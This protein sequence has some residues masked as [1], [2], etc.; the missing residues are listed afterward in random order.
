MS[1]HDSRLYF[2]LIGSVI[3]QALIDYWNP[4]RY[5]N[6]DKNAYY[7]AKE[8]LFTKRLDKFLE[9]YHIDSF[10][11]AA[12]IRKIARE[13]KLF[14]FKNTDNFLPSEETQ[15]EEALV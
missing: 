1:E 4:Q 15:E 7:D 2:M 12:F 9:K 8:F 14:Y 11:N 5:S 6:P 13:R 10:V 3:R